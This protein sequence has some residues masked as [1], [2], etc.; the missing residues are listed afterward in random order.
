MV[1]QKRQGGTWYYQFTKD[2]KMYTGKC[3]G[4]KNKREAEAYE[5]KFMDTVK[6]ASEQKTVKALVDNFRDVLTGSVRIP[7]DDAF[8]L[9]EQKPR[10]RIPAAKKLGL[11]RGVWLDFLA[12]MH[13]EYPDIINLA[14]YSAG[15]MAGIKQKVE[16]NRYE[17]EY[18]C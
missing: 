11:K 18:R 15:K 10:K 9:A 7:L 16:R 6:R 3:E 13:G 17:A 8:E 12:F 5:K 14:P 4:A 2:G 1:R